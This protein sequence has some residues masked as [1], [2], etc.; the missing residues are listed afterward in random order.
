MKQ[1]HSIILFLFLSLAFAC[2]Q[3]PDADK[4]KT[5][6]AKAK[7]HATAGSQNYKV[8]TKKSSITFIGTKPTGAHNGTIQLKSGNVSMKGKDIESGQFV[9]DMN[10]LKILDMDEE[11]NGKLAGHLKNEDFFEVTKFPEA[12]FTLTGSGPFDATKYTE[13]LKLEGANSLI[14]GNLEMKR[15]F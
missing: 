1:I 4:A 8:E 11:N 9:I 7:S 13:E 10:S 14:S 2:K 6:D 5:G 3:A 12:K 15:C